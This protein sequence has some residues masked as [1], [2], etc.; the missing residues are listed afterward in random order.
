MKAKINYEKLCHDFC[1]K[2][3]THSKFGKG[4][5]NLR[6]VMLLIFKIMEKH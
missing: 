2:T 6:S 4:I 1:N 3:Y 5:V